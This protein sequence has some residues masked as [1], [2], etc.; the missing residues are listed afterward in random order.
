MDEVDA[1]IASDRADLVARE[2][3]ERPPHRVRDTST[4][5]ETDLTSR[6]GNDIGR[7]QRDRRRA[8]AAT[9]PAGHDEP[10]ADAASPDDRPVAA[11]RAAMRDRPT[12]SQPREPR[13][14]VAGPD[15]RQRCPW[16]LSAPDYVG[17]HDDEWGRPITS[18]NGIFERLD[19]RGVPVGALVAHHPAEAAEFPRGLRRVRHRCRREHSRPADRER[20][21]AD[22]GIVRNRA[23]VDAAMANARAALEI[24]GGLADLV[25]SFAP[26]RRRAPRTLADVPALTD[27]SQAL[28][29]ELRRRGF[30]FVGPTT[31]Y[32]LMQA[33]GLVNDHLRDC[34]AR[35]RV[36]EEVI[37]P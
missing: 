13:C 3:D 21:L 24:D 30:V 37:A 1:L 11:T 10:S 31:L 15:G 35:D 16:G 33:A 8:S 27:E 34:W 28:A 25:W 32:A 20:L 22:A 18:D 12:T 2:V 36:R 9:P 19:A 5:V 4:S 26:A 14:L 29:K 17:Y 6:P 23:K 7:V